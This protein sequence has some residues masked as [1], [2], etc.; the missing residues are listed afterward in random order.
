MAVHLNEHLTYRKIFRLTISPILMMIFTSI[1]TIVDGLFIANFAGTSAFAG[2]NL[3]FPLCMVVGGVG[4]MFGTGG[5]ALVSK[6]L[7]MQQKERANAAFSMLV[8]FTFAL[9]VLL[10]FAGFFLVEPFARWMASLTEN[11]TE[12]MIKEAISYGH[13]LMAG[14]ALFMMQNLFQSFFQTAERPH[15]GFFFTLFAGITNAALDAMFIAGLRW[16]V[17]GAASATI[18]GYGVGALGPLLYFLIKRDGVIVLGKPKFEARELLQAAGNG[19]SEFVSNISS[20]VL[21]MVFNFQLLRYLG[22]DG[23]SAYGIILYVGFVFMAIFIGFAIGLSPVVGYNFGAGNKKELK[24]ILIKALIC[25]GVVGLIMFTIGES[26][27]NLISGVFAS[28][29]PALKELATRAVR[30][31]SFSYLFAGI[32][33]FISSFFTALNNGLISAIISFVRTLVFQLAFVLLIPLIFGADGIWLAPTLSE[34]GSLLLSFFFLFK[35]RKRYGYFDR[36]SS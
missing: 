10:S 29:S 15:L 16:G 25:M 12:E 22:E 17:V 33:I 5:N 13:I 26:M 19:S 18:I 24:N 1:Y 27:A 35:E 8:Y 28:D 14:Q 2:V 34:V 6:Y 31:Y 7:G 30:F 32:G 3:I 11:N 21:A 20:S 36:T 23:V 9:G 4:F